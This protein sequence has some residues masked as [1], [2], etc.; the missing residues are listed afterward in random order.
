M[1]A[2][3]SVT[4]RIATVTVVVVPVMAPVIVVPMPVVP[5]V[6]AVVDGNDLGVGGLAPC[7]RS[8]RCQRQAEDE[9]FQSGP[10]HGSSPSHV[11]SH[12]RSLKPE[13]DWPASTHSTKEERGPYAVSEDFFKVFFTAAILIVCPAIQSYEHLFIC[14]S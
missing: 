13:A 10:K 3:P 11:A 1:T 7:H 14:R 6:T 9:D 12:R 8:G 4:V 5:I 2:V